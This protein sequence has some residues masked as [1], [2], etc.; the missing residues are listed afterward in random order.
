[1]IYSLSLPL[2][3]LPYSIPDSLSLSVS[4]L[5]FVLLLV[6]IEVVVQVKPVLRL[7]FEYDDHC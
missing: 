3:L 6:V 4:L 2:L 1:M 5:V 7:L